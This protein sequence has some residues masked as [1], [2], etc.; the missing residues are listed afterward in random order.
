MFGGDG[1]AVLVH[2]KV[3][4]AY[5][6]TWGGL[7]QA[8]YAQLS[9]LSPAE[10]HYGP[11]AGMDAQRLRKRWRSGS[12]GKILSEVWCSSC[13]HLCE[14]MLAVDVGVAIH[15]ETSARAP[16]D[17]YAS[18]LLNCFLLETSVRAPEDVFQVSRLQMTPSPCPALTACRCFSAFGS[19][20]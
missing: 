1:Y 13:A 12:W 10:D 17:Q 15:M 19:T 16:V 6:V 9:L 20:D 11:S 18:A 5:G 7:W 4:E 2:P 3:T 14:L 8:T